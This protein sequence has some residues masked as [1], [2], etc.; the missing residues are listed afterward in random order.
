MPAKRFACPA[1]NA[2]MAFDPQ[3][4]RLRCSYCGVQQDV[5]ED[6][7]SVRELPFAEYGSQRLERISEKALEV[8]CSSC[9]S[10]VEFEPPEVAGTCPFC[11]APIVAQPKA[12][13]PMVAPHAVLPVRIPQQSAS[14]SVGQWLSSRW[15]APDGLK[16]IARPDGIQGV[17]VPT[18][19]FDAE[20][21]TRYTGSRGTY[22][23]VQES[24]QE[25]VNG[26]AVQRIRQVRKIRWKPCSGQVFDRFDDV[27]VN[28]TRAIDRRRLDELMPWDLGEL[29]CYEPAFL[30]GFKAQRYQIELPQAWNEAQQI[31]RDA[32]YSTVIQD[33]GGDVQQVS[34]LDPRFSNITF[35]HV[36]LPVWIGAYRF[37]GKVYQVLVN[38]RT[39]EVQGDRPYS[40]SKILMALLAAL[41]FITLVAIL[42][43]R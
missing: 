7:Q 10:V 22:Y 19:T 32:I 21:L 34:S 9:G 43:G 40:A 24:F 30:A 23:Y 26:Q 41:L 35:K 31:M 27:L 25:F 18:W 5:P 8:G 13:D 42:G 37:Q 28:A 2:N 36:L 3:A 4:G 38:A 39:G 6:K 16:R 33:I 12:A 11:A 29:R 15:F 1:C 14:A 20:A 17:Y